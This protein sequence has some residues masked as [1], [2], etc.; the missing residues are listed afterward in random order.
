MVGTVGSRYAREDKKKGICGYKRF[1]FPLIKQLVLVSM[2]SSVPHE[3]AVREEAVPVPS[4]H[5]S[6][7]LGPAV[8]NTQTVR[9]SGLT[10][11]HPADSSWVLPDAHI[12]KKYH[13]PKS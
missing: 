10:G 5:N 11:V 6:F 4:P 2:S 13:T 9:S 12:F 3:I 8:I 7:V 1:L